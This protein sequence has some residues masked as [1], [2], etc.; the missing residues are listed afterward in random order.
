MT[1]TTKLK[2]IGCFFAALLV[3][4]L[5]LVSFLVISWGVFWIVLVV[6]G[7]IAYWVIPWYKKRFIQ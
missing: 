7:V 3:L 2:L 1:P 4:N 5:V 6:I